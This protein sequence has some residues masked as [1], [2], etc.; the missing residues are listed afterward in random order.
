[1]QLKHVYANFL[2]LILIISIVLSLSCGK[3]MALP[4]DWPCF[5]FELNKLETITDSKDEFEYK[6]KS[7]TSLYTV[8]INLIGNHLHPNLFANCGTSGCR[9]IVS[10]NK[11]GKSENLRFFC[12]SYSDNYSKVICRIAKGDEFI[13]NKIDGNYQTTYCSNNKKKILTF[14]KDKC[15]ACHCVIYGKGDNQTQLKM[16]CD[17]RDNVAH[18]FSYN[19]YEEWRNFENNENDFKNCV[20]LISD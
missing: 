18:C 9:G 12:E 1:M 15:N 16:G 6:Y 20:N 13:F 5:D 3:V 7:E 17:F 10:D 8:E 11:T 2:I 19:G 14:N 4:Q